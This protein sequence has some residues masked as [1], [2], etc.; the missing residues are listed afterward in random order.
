[1]KAVSLR[2]FSVA[3]ACIALVEPAFERHDRGRIAGQRLVGERIDLEEGEAV[4][5]LFRIS[6][7]AG[8]RGRSALGID[9]DQDFGAREAPA[10]LLLDAVEPV[11]GS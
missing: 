6:W 4:M 9:V 1:M 10:E 8:S 3:I 11:V 5:S 7:G 2:L